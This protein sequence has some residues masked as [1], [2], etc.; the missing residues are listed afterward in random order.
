MA[1]NPIRAIAF[2]LDGTLVDSGPSLAAAMAEAL[3][4]VG[5]APCTHADALSWIGNGALMLTKRALSNAIEPDPQL[6]PQLIEQ[7]LAAFNRCYAGHQ[8][9]PQMLYPQVAE[10][11]AILKQRGYRI[12]VVTNKPSQFVAEILAATGIASYVEC[13]YGG[14]CLPERKPSPLA[15]TTLLERWHLNPSQLLMVGDSRNDIQ[16]AQAAGCASVGLT[17]GYNYGE[18]IALDRPSHVY[19]HFNQLLALLPALTENCA[20]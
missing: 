17:Y 1:N 8:P 5:R 12:A 10:V 7:T 9:S 6:E 13:W 2:D 11:L 19:D 15:L 3:V 20:Q 16:A 14:D 4:E 18:P